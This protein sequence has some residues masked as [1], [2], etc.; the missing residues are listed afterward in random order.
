MALGGKNIDVTA[1][2]ELS[3]EDAAALDIGL[4][5][6]FQED[7]ET[8]EALWKKRKEALQF[9]LDKRYGE[10][11]AKLRLN[12]S[13]DTGTVHIKTGELQVDCELQKK[14]EWDQ[15]QMIAIRDRIANGGGDPFAYM[16]AKYDMT[17]TAFNALQPAVKA[18]FMP[19]RTVK[20]SKP[21][22]TISDPA[23]TK[24]K[25]RRH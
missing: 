14:V 23:A 20:P 8:A 11:A 19:A 12:E 21:K 22:Y 10:E 2:D 7:I 6:D 4:L 24:P 3:P 9:A 15:E 16:R 17:E 1:L 13:K 25:R 5:A 18:V